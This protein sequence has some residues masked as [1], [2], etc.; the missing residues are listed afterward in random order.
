MSS[1]ERPEADAMEQLRPVRPEDDEEVPE[2]YP[3]EADPADAAEQ[4]RDVGSDDED[5]YPPG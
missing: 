2:A 1:F 4:Q 3:A 5:D